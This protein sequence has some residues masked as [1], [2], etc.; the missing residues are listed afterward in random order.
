MISFYFV[1]FSFIVFALLLIFSSFGQFSKTKTENNTIESE[2]AIHEVI[3]LVHIAYSITET[4]KKHKWFIKKNNK[5]YKEVLEHF[6]QFNS[7]ELIEKINALMIKNYSYAICQ[8]SNAFVFIFDE[9]NIIKNNYDEFYKTGSI[10]KEISLWEDF[11]MKSNFRSF[12]QSHSEYYDSIIQETHQFL[13][14]ESM[15]KWLENKFPSQHYDSYKIAISPLIGGT[16]NTIRNKRECIMFV[17]DASPKPNKYSDEI[18]KGK[19][20]RVV[21]TEID[22]NYVNPISNKYSKHINK[23]MNDWTSW[24]NQKQESYNNPISTFNE[25]MTWAVFTLYLYD[26]YDTADFIL[27]HESME[28]FMLD[29]RGF[30]KFKEFNQAL[31]GI[32]KKS[33]SKNIEELYPQIISWMKT[34]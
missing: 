23:V 22:H 12:Y 8:R 21:F 25:Y 33:E 13:P 11:A 7:H 32:Y 16:H 18:W 10:Q 29:Y 30:N 4:G 27:L 26:N 28:D 2:I 20:S 34:Q 19:Y 6:G 3:E 5:Y 15:W 14:I 17:S 24:N 1:R 9:N 31:L